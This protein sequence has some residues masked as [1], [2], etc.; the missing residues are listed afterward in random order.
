MKSINLIQ[1]ET[2]WNLAQTVAGHWIGVMTTDDGHTISDIC[3]EDDAIDAG[4]NLQ[5]RINAE[6]DRLELECK[7]IENSI[8]RMQRD[9]ERTYRKYQMAIERKNLAQDFVAYM[10][11]P[12]DERLEV[13]EL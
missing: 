2:H 1:E 12:N 8:R 6:A 9:L 11:N 5:Q 13:T 3:P 4:K 7:A 10:Q